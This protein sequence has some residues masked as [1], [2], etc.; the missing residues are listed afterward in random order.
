ML[1]TRSKQWERLCDEAKEAHA[2]V[3]QAIHKLESTLALPSVDRPQEWRSQVREEMDALVSCLQHHCEESERPGG[4]ISE[5]EL[6]QGHSQDLTEVVHAHHRVLDAAKAVMDEL[7][8]GKKPE[9]RYSLLRRQAGHLTA[10]VR[11]HEAKEIDLIYET[12]WRV[13]GGGD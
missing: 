12:F 6:V 4:L 13:S 9:A 2:A 3:L 11:E 10:A 7:E 5:M 8:R 1:E